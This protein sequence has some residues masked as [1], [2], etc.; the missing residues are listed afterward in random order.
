MADRYSKEQEIGS[1]GNYYGCLHVRYDR[2]KERYQWG[3]ENYNGI[4][5]EK[6][7]HYL[8]TA[9]IDFENDLKDGER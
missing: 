4:R 1:I 8:A 9:L 7:P 2:K 3:I 5:W 6:I